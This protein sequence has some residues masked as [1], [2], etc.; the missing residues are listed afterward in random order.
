MFFLQL[1]ELEALKG[2]LQ[3]MGRNFYKN[4]KKSFLLL[5]KPFDFHS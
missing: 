2:G 1:L 5:P 4:N 3:I